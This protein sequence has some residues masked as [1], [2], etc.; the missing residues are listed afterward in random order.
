MDVPVDQV[1]DVIDRILPALHSTLDQ[2]SFLI[3]RKAYG[4][5]H[6]R[7]SPG[8][9]NSILSGYHRP[10]SLSAQTP[11]ANRLPGCSGQGVAKPV[12]KR[13]VPVGS[14]FHA[15]L[16][17]DACPPRDGSCAM[18]RILKQGIEC[19]PAPLPIL[20][21]ESLRYIRYPHLRSQLAAAS[22]DPDQ[23]ARCQAGG[24]RAF[25]GN[26]LLPA[27]LEPYHVADAPGNV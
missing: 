22:A 27:R 2:S 5:T 1:A 8:R 16:G 10:S 21:E 7:L 20:T 12:K 13:S 17:P 9:P 18:K 19:M 3:W 26:G 6:C 23:A 25:R 15:D 11:Y 4:N 24:A 14:R